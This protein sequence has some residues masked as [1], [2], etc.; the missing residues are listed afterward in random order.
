VAEAAEADKHKKELNEKVGDSNS[1]AYRL[2]IDPTKSG[3]VID[4]D[5]FF[6]DQQ[7]LAE[8]KEK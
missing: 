1:L 3:F 7:L 6:V 2:R 8:K 4:D 5:D